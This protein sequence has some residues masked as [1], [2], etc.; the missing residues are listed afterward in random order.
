M[1]NNERK[2][3]TLAVIKLGVGE[4]KVVDVISLTLDNKLQNPHPKLVNK[5]FF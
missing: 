3:R 5:F 2:L 1:L 4:E